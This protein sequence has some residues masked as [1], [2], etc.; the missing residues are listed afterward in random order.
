MDGVDISQLFK[1]I[2]VFA[3]VLHWSVGVDFVRSK[4]QS[5]A[6]SLSP[7]QREIKAIM[8]NLSHSVFCHPWYCTTHRS[9]V[10]PVAQFCTGRRP[11]KLTYTVCIIFQLLGHCSHFMN[12]VPNFKN[13]ASL[14]LCTS[15]CY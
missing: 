11:K 2:F 15:L 13:A 5:K 9:N 10:V 7:S 8:L 14:M 3:L 1:A 12:I 6:Q 4:R